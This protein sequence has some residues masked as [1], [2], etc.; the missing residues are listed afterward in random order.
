MAEPP[1]DA[2]AV[3][4]TL[5]PPPI[6][7]AVP[8]VG[9]P[10]TVLP[11]DWLKFGVS[12]RTTVPSIC[13]TGSALGARDHPVV[14]SGDHARHVAVPTSAQ[15]VRSTGRDLG[16]G[17]GRRRVLQALDE[18]SN[19]RW[20]G[21]GERLAGALALGH[22]RLLHGLELQ[23]ELALGHLDRVAQGFALHVELGLL[24]LVLLE[25]ELEVDG[26]DL[27]SCLFDDEGQ[28]VL[29]RQHALGAGLLDLLDTDAALSGELRNALAA[30]HL[31]LLAL[32]HALELLVLLAELSHARLFLTQGRE[33]PRY[34]GVA[35]RAHYLARDLALGSGLHQHRCN[36]GQDAQ[37]DLQAAH[38][39]LG[40]G[41]AEAYVDHDAHR[42]L[43]RAE[44]LGT[45]DAHLVA[46]DLR[47]ALV[48]LPYRDEVHRVGE[49]LLHP[50]LGE[51]A[52]GEL[53]DLIGVVGDE[54]HATNGLV[55]LPVGLD[56]AAGE[57][58]Q[59]IIH[60]GVEEVLLLV[61][62][63]AHLW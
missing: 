10:G 6:A 54:L 46:N 23:G 58:A 20:R 40:V 26:C 62:A 18:R 17:T 50:G 57:V 63:A 37:A 41:A 33:E 42:R 19:A 61:C 35:Q 25:L 1:V 56:V 8:T 59:E 2:G 9:A 38:A 14:P 12:V 34:L 24:H 4:A 5:A 31:H 52:G 32:E 53:T 39:A 51:R 3:K 30:L 7:V 21:I 43:E 48:G 11:P 55:E 16:S 15:A 49:D 47:H 36:R 28:L 29:E 13:R 44:Y 60:L 22:S 45:L 27:A